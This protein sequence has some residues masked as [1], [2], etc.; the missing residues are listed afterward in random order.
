MR[1]RWN[2]KRVDGAVIGGWGIIGTHAVSSEGNLPLLKPHLG[3][4]EVQRTKQVF[5]DVAGGHL[6]KGPGRVQVHSRKGRGDEALIGQYLGRVCL[7][8]RSTRAKE[9]KSSRRILV[10]KFGSPRGCTQS[11]RSVL[12][13]QQPCMATQ[14]RELTGSLILKPVRRGEVS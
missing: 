2:S 1:A 7:F 5:K 11:L 3:G 4:S 13:V 14:K 8:N 6:A 10:S 9:Q 12:K